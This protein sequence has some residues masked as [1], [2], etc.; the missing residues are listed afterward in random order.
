MTRRLFILASAEAR[1]NAAA[2]CMAAPDRD[3][4][5]FSE[6]T[7]NLEQNAKMHAV[8][9][10]IAKQAKYLGRVLTLPQWKT[11]LISGHAVATG[12]GADMVPGLEGEFVNIRESSASMSVARMASVIEYALAYGA[13]NGVVFDGSAS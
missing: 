10:D 6:P 1:R 8:F 5:R 11:L 4:V 3:Y 13:Q 2:Y 9:G 12:L 7:R